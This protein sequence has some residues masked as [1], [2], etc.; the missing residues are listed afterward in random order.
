MQFPTM[1]SPYNLSGLELKNRFLMAP[2]TRS[3]T[4]Q[5]GDIP[6]ELMAEY[7][8]QRAAAG[9]IITEAT[10]VNIQGQGYARTPGIATKEQIKGWKK[11][12]TAVHEKNTPIF[13]QIWH[14]GRMSSSLVNGLQPIGPSALIAE[15][16]SVYI[17]DNVTK[18]MIA[19]TP[20]EAPRA[21]EAADFT[22]VNNQ[23][24]QAAL[25]AMEAGFDGVE[26]HG[27]NAY[28][29]DQFLRRN[30]NR[31]TDMY[32][33]SIPNRIRFPMELIKG[34]AQAI[35][36]EKVGIRFSPNVKYKNMD[37]PEIFDAILMAAQ[38]LNDLGIAYIHLAEGDWENGPELDESFRKAL[39]LAFTKTIIAT[40]SK[41]PEKGETL[42]KKGYANLIGFGRSFVA[43]PDFPIRVLTGAP[44]N[45]I[46][47]RHLLYG[48]GDHIGYSDYP[49]I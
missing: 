18:G 11:I 12:T 44:L 15:E 20:V 45:E 28:L 7:Y 32:G 47:D 10:Y 34:V 19:F 14:T 8:A 38:Q 9:I 48:G 17:E 43:N 26:L 31:R 49:A 30:S 3:R 46:T 21:M 33:G 5:P 23:F 2:M 35:G 4:S 41:T 27:A 13:L 1:F 29:I 40:G 37:D 36:K 6:N 16:A 22:D 25:H 39:R 42:L 24:V